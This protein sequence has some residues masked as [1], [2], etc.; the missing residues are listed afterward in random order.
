MKLLVRNAMIYKTDDRCFREGSVICEDGVFTAVLNVADGI[1]A[2]VSADVTVDAEGK[3]L[4]P[5]LVDVHTHGRAGGD[6]ATADPD[7]LRVMARSYLLS[8]VTS[9]MPTLASAPFEELYAAT[10]RIHSVRS[11]TGGA[12]FIGTH[13]E[14]R[15][16]NPEKRGAHAPELLRAPDAEELKGLMERMCLPCHVSAA[17]ELDTDGSF[18][19]AALDFGATLSLGHTSA[20]YGE[21]SRLFSEGVTA[22]TH[23][24]NA[25][26]PIHHREGGAAVAAMTGNVFCELIVDG[27]HV[28]APVV[29]MTSR[30]TAPDRLVLITDSMEATDCPDGEYSIAGMPVTV[31]DGK[32]LTHDGAIAGSTLSLYDGVK[33]LMQFAEISFSE[34]IYAATAAPAKEI[35][36]FDRLGSVDVGKYADFLLIDPDTLN[37]GDIYLGGE[38]AL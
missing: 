3:Y 30:L 14:G 1:P 15:Y 36:V 7:R 11:R 23:L 29:R 32:A 4:I 33:N 8:G 24:Y 17:L 26:P 20:T 10:D 18:I 16:L 25:M 9:V 21:A 22:V 35:A 27:F 2:D 31:R 5:G 12:R 13:L 6:F 38:R 34:A 19:K 28:S 37:I